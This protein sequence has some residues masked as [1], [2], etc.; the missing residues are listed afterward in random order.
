MIQRKRYAK[1][2]KGRLMAKKTAKRA[3]KKRIKGA[4]KTGQREKL[5]DSPVSVIIPAYNTAKFISKAV[6]SVLAQSYKNFELIVIDDGSTDETVASVQKYQKADKRVK[7]LQN[8]KNLGSA[9]ARNRGIR[10]AQGRYIAFLDSDDTWRPDKLKKQVAFMQKNSSPL[11]FTSYEVYKQGRYLRTIL[12]EE[13]TNY[14][15]LIR[16]HHIGCS[17]A[18]YDT[19]IM[20]KQFMIEKEQLR[21]DLAFWLTILQK[22]EFA[23]GLREALTTYTIR[24]ESKSSNRLKAIY[25]T[26]NTYRNFTANRP[27]KTIYFFCFYVLRNLNSRLLEGKRLLRGINAI[28]C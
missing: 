28:F 17:T 11:S 4:A 6:E 15:Q 23:S 16:G 22:I 26:Y 18:I 2:H 8:R 1:D 5:Q 20:G 24:N 3:T 10:A 9:C 19:C 21:E 14:R 7:L 12:A 27:A 13:K 25:R